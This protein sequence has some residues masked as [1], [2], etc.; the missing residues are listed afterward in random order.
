MSAFMDPKTKLLAL[1]CNVLWVSLLI[2]ILLGGHFEHTLAVLLIVGPIR[3]NYGLVSPTTPAITS[4]VWIPIFTLS[5]FE[6]RR[7]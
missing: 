6:L 3:E 7:V 4:P 1:A 2:R 5:F